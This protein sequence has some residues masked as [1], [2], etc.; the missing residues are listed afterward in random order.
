MA[1]VVECSSSHRSSRRRSSRGGGGGGGGGG[2]TV[3]VVVGVVFL[4]CF[5]TGLT[6][7]KVR[8]P[9]EVEFRVRAHSRSRFGNVT[10]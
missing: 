6:V 2:G 9:S 4:K 3:V 10:M 1:I 8:S 5:Y 7:M